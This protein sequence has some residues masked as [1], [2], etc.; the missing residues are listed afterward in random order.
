MSDEYSRLLGKG[1][2]AQAEEEYRHLFDFFCRFFEWRG[3]SDPEDLAQTVFE[4]GLTRIRQ[5]EKVGE[6]GLGG[7]LYGIARF[8]LLEQRRVRPSIPLPIERAGDPGPHHLRSVEMNVL[9]GQSLGRL[10]PDER[11]LLL[12]YAAGERGLAGYSAEALRVHVHRLRRK[13]LEFVGEN[14]RKES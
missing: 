12:D 3:C 13:V 7:Y 1:D 5:G 10:P 14:R 9:I 11:E 2:P 4:R 6:S 8:V